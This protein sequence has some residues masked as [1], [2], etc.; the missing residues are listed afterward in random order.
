MKRKVKTKT[1]MYR[2]RSLSY[3]GRPR[4]QRQ[5]PD[6]FSFSDHPQ[7]RLANVVINQHRA[8]WQST[9][10]HEVIAQVPKPPHC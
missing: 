9:L 10:E 8:I 1:E 5:S 4:I 2:G 3:I 7:F 6:R